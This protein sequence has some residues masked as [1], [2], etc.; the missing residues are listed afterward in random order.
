MKKTVVTAAALVMLL[1]TIAPAA[2]AQEVTGGC[3][4]TVNGQTLDTLDIKHPLIVAKG[5]VLALTGSVPAAAGTGNVSSETKIYVEIIG[6]IPVA[7]Q[8]G[9]GMTWGDWVEVP[10]VLT[11]LAP[12]VYKVKGTATGSGW[13]CTG[14]AY[15]RVEGGPLT[16]ATAIGAV[17]AVAGGAA[18]VGAIK[19]KKGQVFH[20]GGPPGSGGEPIRETSTRLAADVVTL[21]L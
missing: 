20:E 7:E 14:S 8:T 4:A 16:A 13:L 5:D 1:V 19:P 15:I 10:D 17:L 21:G 6:D 12:G 2:L 11:S 18:A 3:S 9:D